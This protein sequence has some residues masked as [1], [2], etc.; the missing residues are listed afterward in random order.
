MK[1]NPHSGQLFT[2]DHG[3][4]CCRPNRRRLLQGIVAATAGMMLPA[5]ALWPAQTPNRGLIDVHRHYLAPRLR[6]Q[7]AAQGRVVAIFES[8]TPQKMLAD[9][10]TLAEMAHKSQV[11]ALA[12]LTGR[13][14]ANMAEVQQMLA[15]K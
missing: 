9:M 5:Q 11:D 1:N 4:Q 10:K 8:D 2:A 12:S 15:P 13:A 7:M 14:K 6:A 3:C